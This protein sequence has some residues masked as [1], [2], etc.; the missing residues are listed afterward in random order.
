MLDLLDPPGNL[1][2]APKGSLACQHIIRINDQ[3]LI[4]LV[5]RGGNAEQVEIVDYH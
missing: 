1:L 3:W 5:W 2:E 4:C